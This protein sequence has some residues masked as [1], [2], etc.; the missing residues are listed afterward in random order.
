MVKA[1]LKL[2]KKAEKKARKHEEAGNYKRASVEYGNAASNLAKAAKYTDNPSI[3]Q[4]YLERADQYLEASEKYSHK[5]RTVE[6]G[7][8]GVPKEEEEEEKLPAI[9][10]TIVSEKPDVT[11]SD[12][13]GL[14]GPKSR[15]KEAII[16]PMERPEFFEGPLEP[17]KGILLFGP[18]GCGKTLLAKASANECEA[19]FFNVS[20]ADV[21]SKWFGES[22]KLIKTL[23]QTADER[24]PSII[25]VD[26]VDSIAP[27]RTSGES[28]A[29]R[30]VLTQM[31]RE[32]DGVEELEDVLIIAATNVPWILD[33]ALLRR[34]EKRIYI[35]MPDKDAR[36]K[37]L[38][39][40]LEGGNLSEDLDLDLIAEKTEGYSGSDL[41]RICREATMMPLR[42]AEESG[43]L[44]DS[45]LE[46]RPVEMKDFERAVERVSS[47]VTE[48]HLQKYQKWSQ[49]YGST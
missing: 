13:G 19:T 37:I 20:A 4:M 49:Q 42:E 15:I 47:T 41:E 31:L 46:L 24:P 2:A 16:L 39:I 12:I 14:E 17:W 32:M 25:F 38:E 6:T 18:P 7:S 43:N 22:E 9:M 30:R 1:F 40:H 10:D 36:R 44:M 11:W 5:K 21:L 48:E 23:F 28:G 3:R 35:P 29:E 34:F 26:E 8:E 27:E 33:T 45:D